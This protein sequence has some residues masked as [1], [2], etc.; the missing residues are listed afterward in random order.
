MPTILTVVSVNIFALV[1]IHELIMDMGLT[2]G[3]DEN[4]NQLLIYFH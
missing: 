4:H 2:E 1:P 3:A